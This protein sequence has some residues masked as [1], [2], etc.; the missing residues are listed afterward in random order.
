MWHR[1][2]RVGSVIL[3]AALLPSLLY[4]DHWGEFV[5]F[6]LGRADAADAAEAAAHSVHCH[7][8]AASCS[9]QPVPTNLSQLGTIVE[10]PEPPLPAVAL[11]ERAST[12]EEF[13]VTPPTEPPRL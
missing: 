6:A 10:V 8:G 13:V 12:P 4:I 11:E 3:L 9:D 2:L 5:D 1:A 7:F